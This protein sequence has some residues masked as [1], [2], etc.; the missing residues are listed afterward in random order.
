VILTPGASTTCALQE[1]D[2]VNLTRLQL[3]GGCIS[4]GIAGNLTAKMLRYHPMEETLG[5]DG[6]IHSVLHSSLV[7][8]LTADC[9][10]L[11]LTYTENEDL[12]LPK[13]PV[14]NSPSPATE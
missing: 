6:N 11:K 7:P 13:S 1:S 3:F 8:S 4:G 14:S 2:F 5:D 9:S 12:G 10:A